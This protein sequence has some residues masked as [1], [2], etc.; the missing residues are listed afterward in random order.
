MFKFFI[1]FRVITQL[2]YRGY[3]EDKEIVAERIGQFTDVC[4]HFEIAYT[5][6]KRRVLDRQN[7]IRNEDN[8][9]QFGTGKVLQ[10][11]WDCIITPKKWEEFCFEVNDYIKDKNYATFLVYSAP[12]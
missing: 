3:N 12:W 2:D 4:K 1:K 5:S 6:S 11:S 9:I 7:P 10:L 8:V